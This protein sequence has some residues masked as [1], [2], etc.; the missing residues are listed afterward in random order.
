MT[1]GK[2]DPF[3]NQLSGATKFKSCLLDDLDTPQWPSRIDYIASQLTDGEYQYG[4]GTGNIELLIDGRDLERTARDYY[5]QGISALT[6]NRTRRTSLPDDFRLGELL[7]QFAELRDGLNDVGVDIPPGEILSRILLRTVQRES[8]G[9]EARLAQQIRADMQTPRE[10]ITELTTVPELTDTVEA[11]LP[12]TDDPKTLV[13]ELGNL[14]LTTKLWDHQRESLLL[15]LHHGMNGYVDMA[16]AT[17]K[18]VLGLSAVA[19]AVDTG[20][21]HPEDSDELEEFFEDG[22]PAP[23]RTRPSD[24]LIVTTDELLGVQ[25]ARLFQDHCHTPAEYTKIDEDGIQLPNFRID[26]R[27]ADGLADVSPSE[28]RLA[29]FDE[30]HNYGSLSGWG[31]GLVEFV[32]SQCPVLALTGS[33]TDELE[34][35][36]DRTDES[37][38]L[39]YRYTHALALDDGV[40]PDF[41]WTLQFTDVDRSEGMERF[42]NTAQEFDRLVDYDAGTYRIDFDSIASVA[43]DL[44]E[45]AMHD[46]AGEYGSGTAVA[47]SLREV[48]SDG[49]A[50]TDRLES[51]ASGLS[52]RSI[53]RLNL[54]TNLETVVEIAEDALSAGRPVLVLTRSYAES[55]EIWQ[56]LYDRHGDRVIKRLEREQSAEKHD[57]IIR[58]FDD[59]DTDEKAF[60]GPGKRIGE[61]NDIHSVEVGINIA[62][63]VSGVNATLVQRLGRLLRDAGSKDSVDFHHVLG[64]PPADANIEPDG[65]SFVRAVTE[66]FGQV[67]DPG[68]DGILK[69]PSVDIVEGVRLDVAALERLGVSSIDETDQS[70]VIE[71]AYAAAIHEQTDD[72]PAVDTGWFTA[73]FGDTD[74]GGANEGPSREHAEAT[75][76]STDGDDAR[77][78]QADAGETAHSVSS[79]HAESDDE[80]ELADS[81]ANGDTVSRSPLAEHYD[82]FLNLCIVHDALLPQRS[83]DG[84]DGD[85]FREWTRNVKSMISEKGFE[86]QSVGYGP[87]LS[88]RHDISIGEYRTE[89]GNEHLVTDYETLDVT[90]VPRIVTLLLEGE[91]SDLS[92]LVVPVTPDGGTPLP[93]V[94]ESESELKR[95]RR[96]LR[97]F[98]AEPPTETVEDDQNAPEDIDSTSTLTPGTVPDQDRPNETVSTSSAST[99]SNDGPAVPVEDVLGVSESTA[100][101][102]RSAGYECKSDLR[103]ASDEELQAVDGVSTQRVTLVRAAVGSS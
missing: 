1:P 95:G 2:H 14:D 42:R 62:P 48:G 67:L 87:Q 81:E 39:V 99:S 75:K 94:V 22:V 7:V 51:L 50:P 58:A 34:T 88:N 47:T 36:A 21:L 69:P 63:P 60:I 5:L 11:A 84:D 71:S 53:N 46:I 59:A 65:E 8:R 44:A 4:L 3:K 23:Q 91:L 18:T 76:G 10:L 77:E 38:P 78:N 40:I 80:T 61:G 101:A 89:F 29:I 98:P 12:D 86:T 102:L 97:E 26:I 55:K 33:V 52:N 68:T 79:D 92:S 70:I 27:S 57:E 9:V 90:S 28:Y 83:S 66:F 25:W 56:S 45:S 64:V 32:D 49:T 54:S 30:V 74:W 41:E 17:G 35:L 19:H 103:S 73:A 16:T 24:V 15:W 13:G 6:D 100:E 37:F 72:D 31:R 85:P 93:V 43:P 20:S 82:A 96:L